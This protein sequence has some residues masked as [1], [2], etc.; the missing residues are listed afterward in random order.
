MDDSD[1]FFTQ[2][3]VG[4]PFTVLLGRRQTHKT[5]SQGG[6]MVNLETGESRL[7]R[8]WRDWLVLNHSDDPVGQPRR[9]P[10][11]VR[12]LLERHALWV[13][14]LGL[15]SMGAALL[16]GGWAAWS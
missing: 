6:L 13:A 14:V 8:L 3:I 4:P 9:R 11:P 12:R 5:P 15:L 7:T 16:V 2:T 10:G 1:L